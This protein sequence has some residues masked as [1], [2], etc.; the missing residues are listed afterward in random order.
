MKLK[1]FFVNRKLLLHGSHIVNGSY[2]IRHFSPPVFLWCVATEELGTTKEDLSNILPLSIRNPHRR[3]FTDKRM[4]FVFPLQAS[5]AT[6]KWN[7]EVDRSLYSSRAY[8]SKNPTLSPI[9]ERRSFIPQP[10]VTE[11]RSAGCTGNML[12]TQWFWCIDHLLDIVCLLVWIS[13]PLSS[14]D[15]TNLNLKIEPAV[16][17][18]QS[19]D[20][21]GYCCAP[22]ITMGTDKKQP[23]LE[24]KSSVDVQLYVVT[25]GEAVAEQGE[26]Q[27]AAAP[28]A[29]WELPLAH[30]ALEP[31]AVDPTLDQTSVGTCS[32]VSDT[33]LEGAVALHAASSPRPPLAESSDNV[34]QRKVKRGR[35]S[36]ANTL[37]PHTGCNAVEGDQ[38]DQ[39]HIQLSS[40]ESPDKGRAASVD[41]APWQSD[42]NLEDVFRPVAT[43]GQR[44][45]RRSL[46]NQSG[47]GQ[48]SAGLAW[49]PRTSPDSIRDV[50]R[51]TRSRRLSAAL[52]PEE[53]WL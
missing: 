40:S 16:P 22:E 51:R 34:R 18:K 50:R 9:K 43:R 7:K 38:L 53:T 21:V 47:K 32:S 30:T 48:S 27:T 31:R 45:V 10:P 35:R 2:K 24:E 17:G 25:A 33:T 15:D 37:Q 5:V 26:E 23:G 14:D 8:A 39:Q 46:R 1:G 11:S 3:D 42:F 20:S 6:R 36:S 44:S 12:E 49:L 28:E 52:L 19:E 4:G 29:S 13:L 41:L